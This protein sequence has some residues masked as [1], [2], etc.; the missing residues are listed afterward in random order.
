P[1][2]PYSTI[3]RYAI[4]GSPRGMLTLAEIYEVVEARFPYY[5]NAGMGWKNSIRHNLSLNRIFEKKPRAITEPGKGAYWTI[6][7]GEEAGPKRVRK[8]K[9]RFPKTGQKKGRGRGC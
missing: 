2:Y 4:E 6:K 3:I 1:P 9:V 5:K 8:R 7:P